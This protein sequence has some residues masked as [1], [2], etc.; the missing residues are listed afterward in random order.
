MKGKK[1]GQSEKKNKEIEK[2]KKTWMKRSELKGF[3]FQ[4]KNRQNPS[5]QQLPRL[6][7]QTDKSQY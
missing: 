6:N 5:V 1:S 2:K 4:I 7:N 3:Y